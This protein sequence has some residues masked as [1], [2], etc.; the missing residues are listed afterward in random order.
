VDKIKV[1]IFWNPKKNKTQFCLLEDYRFYYGSF[2]VITIEAG[3]V[4]D[5]ASVP[6]FLWSILPPI[7]KHNEA[8]LVHDYLYDNKIGT[9][10]N[11]DKF[12]SAMMEEAQVG[13]LARY[14][15]YLGVRL[16]AKSWWLN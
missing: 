6:Q 13:C 9:R 7:G 3:Y 8:A 4:T 10:K 5:F 2:D 11:A 14:T 15:M 1:T 16:F 12:F